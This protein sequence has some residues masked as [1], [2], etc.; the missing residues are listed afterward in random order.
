MSNSKILLP[1]SQPLREAIFLRRP[2]RFLAEMYLSDGTKEH[3]YCANPGSMSGC[4]TFGRNALLWD[5]ENIKRKRRYTWRAVEFEG[6]W[7]GTDTHLSNRIVEEALQLKLVPGLETYNTLSREQLVEEG[8][9]VDFI[10]TGSQGNC[11]VEVKSATVVENGVARYPDSLTPRGVKQLKALTR[12]VEEGQR[13][14][15]IFL[16]QREDAQSFVV[17]NSHDSDYAEAFDKAVVSGVEVIALAVSVC[18]EGFGRPKLLPYAQKKIASMNT[19]RE[20]E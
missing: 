8:F 20:G 10:L 2:Q 13:S 7:I 4:L 16:I 17:S 18:Y 6:L 12:K 9:R 11:L 5:S 14:V 1:F 19:T 3:V 15:L